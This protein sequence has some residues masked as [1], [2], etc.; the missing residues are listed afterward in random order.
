MGG[1][2]GVDLL[3]IRRCGRVA[4]NLGLVPLPAIT[5]EEYKLYNVASVAKKRCGSLLPTAGVCGRR[6][7]GY[8]KDDSRKG[9]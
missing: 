4:D 7:I 8:G 5:R 2:R 9:E 6:G 3:A 1:G